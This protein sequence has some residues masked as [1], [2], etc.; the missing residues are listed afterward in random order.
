MSAP[1]LLLPLD[2]RPVNLDAPVQLAGVAGE[3][4]LVPPTE[5]LGHFLQPGQPDRLAEWLLDS[6]PEARTAIISLDMLA[7]GGLVA[8]RTPAVAGKEARERLQVLRELKARQP[9]LRL[10]AF[11]VIMRLTITGSD[12]ETR[13]AGRDI[14]RYSVL[15]DQAERLGD[16]EAALEL[17]KV[18]ARIPPRLLEAYLAARRRNHSVNR[19]AL[20]LLADGVLDFLALVQEDTAPAG[21][22]V[23]EQ[24]A[25]TELAAPHLVGPECWRIYAGTDEAAM[26]L[27]ARCV[28][29]EANFPFPVIPRF[30]DE[31]AADH[32]A[33][34]EDVPLRETTRRHIDA[35]RG[36][37]ALKGLTLAA[38]TFAPPQPDLFETPPLPEPT[39][40]AAL[41]AFP[42]T[43]VR[44]WL[45]GLPAPLAVADLAYCNGGDPHLLDALLERPAE[46]L[47]SYAGWNTAGNTLGTALAHLALR[48]LA[49]AKG[50]DAE[51]AHRE[52]LLVRLLDD[53]LY[54][55]IVRGWAMARAEEVGASPLNLGSAAPAFEAQV[56]DVLHAL[57]ADLLARYPLAAALDRPFR[58]I[59]PWGRLFEVRIEVMPG[60]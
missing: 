49:L 37:Q 26:T 36:T 10:F 17:A 31:A 23:A 21:L 34:F 19:A 3:R 12:P 27:L 28:L 11:N 40:D 42:R 4:L 58:A 43:N 48:S 50:T 41:D 39:W 15:R 35:A 29:G 18:E 38:H 22:H 20:T 6:A 59:L 9:G 14:F 46:D 51:G 60:G 1:L 13:A 2:D 24:R 57:W 16:A 30:R 44:E 54:Q 52:A 47:L 55:P 8:S 56:D 25:L 7:Y 53:G 45:E 32:P 5:W 33:L